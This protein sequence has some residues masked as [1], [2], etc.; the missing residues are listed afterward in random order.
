[1][2]STSPRYGTPNFEMLK[3]WIG[4]PPELDGP[5][6]ALNLMKYRA[7]AQYDDGRDTAISGRAADD[8]YAPLGP[9]KAVGATVAFH[10]DVARQGAGEPHWDRIGIVCYPTRA[11]FFAMQQRDDFKEKHVHKD[12][13]MECTIVMSCLPDAQRPPVATPDGTLLLRVARLQP[14][15][16]LAE[17]DGAIRVATFDVEG[18]IVGDDRTWS[19]VAF[20][21]AP[22]EGVA[23][24]LLGGSDGVEEMF[25]MVLAR[26]AIDAIEQSIRTAPAHGAA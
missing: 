24:A 19:R 17:V 10:G 25:A 1:M 22:S 12:A 15:A 7:V 20:D 16:D 11:A 4:R 23:E 5:F 6:W 26:P 13:G 2:A 21:A 3:T 14:G 8:A 9:L 18:V